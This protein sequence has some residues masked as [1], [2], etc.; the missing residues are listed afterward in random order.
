[1][2]KNRLADSLSPYL[3]QHA[4]NPVQWQPWDE[5]SLALARQSDKPILL[6][7][8][9][10]ACHWCHVMAH[11][12]F[13]DA[14]TAAAMNDGF[15][16][17][18]V[19]REERPDLDR[20]YQAA[21]YVFTNRAGGWPLTMFLTPHGM[22]FFG[23]TYFPK[24]S[25]RGLLSFVSIMEKVLEAWTQ[26]RDDIE[27]Q[28]AQVSLILQSLDVHATSLSTIGDAP[29]KNAMAAF[30]NAIDNREGGFRGAP[31]FPHPVEMA[32]CLQMAA[33]DDDK[34]LLLAARSSLDKIALGGLH[35]HLAG[36]FFRYC[37]DAQ[38]AIPHFEKMLYDNG[39]LLGVFAEAYRILDNDYYAEV[40]TNTANWC[41]KTYKDGGLNGG[42]GGFYS[43]L[44][45]DS[46]GGEGEF[47]VWTEEQI[48]ALLSADEY[49]VVEAH[50]GLAA[51]GC[52]EGRH[53][54]MQRQT[55][56]QTAAALNRQ[57]DE[58]I[59]LLRQ[60]KDKL[61]KQRMLRSP[62]P[63][64]DKI[65]TAWN[66]LTLGNL[67]RAG[68]IHHQPQW[69]AAAYDAMDFIRHNLTDDEGR[70][71]A[72]WRAGRCKTAAFLDDYAFLLEA[73]IELL[74]AEFRPSLLQYMRELARQLR[75][76]FEDAEGGGFFFSARDAEVLIR[77]VKAIDDNAI[78]SGNGVAARALWRLSK[79]TGDS[80][81]ADVAEKTIK[82]FYGS[83]EKNPAGCASLLS[84][85]HLYLSPS[86]TVFLIGD[87][88]ECLAWR[89]AIERA[90]A[91]DAL[92]FI[93][94]S[95]LS[96]DENLPQM[97]RALLP[98]QPLHNGARAY[99][100]L[101]TSCLPPVESLDEL[102]DLLTA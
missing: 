94:P 95:E 66:G 44:D 23:G 5:Q 96:D 74:R 22:P 2:A 41:L 29:I 8:G 7:I 43:S 30:T 3:I 51:G 62:P 40:M 52:F 32:F 39:L 80:E 100:C 54:L 45:A 10:A 69:V 4:D 78:P 59:K 50:Y 98:S 61:L 26:K 58:C 25:G 13:E 14:A 16:N 9:Y 91:A 38:W 73:G 85:L 93:L 64:D 71:L 87:I 42:N 37:V 90:L 48:R 101:D 79:I 18:K 31:K 47:Y 63:L 56:R 27:K 17:I 102:L 92:V 46:E 28:N 1:M 81:L 12:S 24:E 33:A 76:Y 21:H 19:D 75:E 55:P 89:R 86:P 49:A 83:M 82:T 72:V 35:D 53:H 20:I 97:L 67:A 15:V 70:L 68:R 34:N 99:V 6:S 88:K 65:L 57:Q 11:E 36:G 60:A 84:A 77:R